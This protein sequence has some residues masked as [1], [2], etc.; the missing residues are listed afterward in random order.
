MRLSDTA[1]CMWNCV[2]C[3]SFVRLTSPR[4]GAILTSTSLT[5]S[6]STP[7]SLH[8]MTTG[9]EMMHQRSGQVYIPCAYLPRRIWASVQKSMHGQNAV[10]N[11]EG[12]WKFCMSGGTFSSP[13]WARHRGR[14]QADRLSWLKHAS[15]AFALCFLAYLLSMTGFLGW[16]VPAPLSLRVFLRAY[17]HWHP[18]PVFWCKSQNITYHFS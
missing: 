12:M 11:K 2:D 4:R 15:S 9:Y 6:K 7:K 17:S 16:N 3:G 14:A 8:S 13:C 18:V 1:A 10:I 5:F